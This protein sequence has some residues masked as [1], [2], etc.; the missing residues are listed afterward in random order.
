MENIQKDKNITIYDNCTVKT[1]NNFTDGIELST[2][3][4]D[5]I[6]AKY[7]F[8]CEGSKSSIKNFRL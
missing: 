8:S 7:L 4:D 6:K 3:N 2:I 5:L 1:I